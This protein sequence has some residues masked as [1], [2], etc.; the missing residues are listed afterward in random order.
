MDHGGPGSESRAAV[1][2]VVTLQRV[3]RVSQVS[4]SNSDYD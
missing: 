3:S 1:T 4:L 2:V